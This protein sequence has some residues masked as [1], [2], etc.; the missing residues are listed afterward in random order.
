MT[1]LKKINKR[2]LEPDAQKILDWAKNHPNFTAGAYAFH[3]AVL[4]YKLNLEGKTLF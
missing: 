2:E 4:E 1:V 3:L